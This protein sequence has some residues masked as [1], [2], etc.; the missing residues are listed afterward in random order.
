M[1]ETGVQSLDQNDPLEE[2]NGNPLQYSGLENLMDRGTWQATVHGC[3]KESDTTPEGLNNNVN[4]Y[5]TQGK[6][7]PLP[8]ALDHTLAAHL[9]GKG[10]GIPLHHRPSP[11]MALLDSGRVCIRLTGRTAGSA[12]VESCPSE[13]ASACLPPPASP[14]TSN[15]PGLGGWVELTNTARLRGGLKTSPSSSPLQPKQIPH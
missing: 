12:G 3:R 15:T 1:Q 10:L 11:V 9:A 5:S 4:R 7:H 6:H 8:S 13:D 2:G 14:E